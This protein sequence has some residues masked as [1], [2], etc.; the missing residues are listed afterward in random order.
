MSGE[1]DT[2]SYDQFDDIPSLKDKAKIIFSEKV[3]N[4]LCN[5]MNDSI[6]RFVMILFGTLFSIIA[7]LIS[8]DKK[9]K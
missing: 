5:L 2:V 1:L 3:Y 4:M 7:C 9:E 6:G 8:F